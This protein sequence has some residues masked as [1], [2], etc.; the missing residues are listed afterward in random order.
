MLNTKVLNNPASTLERKQVGDF[1]V[2]YTQQESVS[3]MIKKDLITEP[4]D[5]SFL[6]GMFTT[7][8]S[9]DDMLAGEIKY[10]GQV[11]FEG[12]GGVF[13]VTKFGDVWAS[14]KEGTANTIANSLNKQLKENGGKAFLT[15][16][17]GTDS[18]LVSSASG[19]NSTL[20]NLN[21]MLDNNL[22]SPSSF[23]AA[24]STAVRKA[25]GE[26]NLRQSAKDLK[27]DIEKYFK[28][29]KQR[30]GLSNKCFASGNRM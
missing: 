20:A 1:E 3:E 13:F 9:P 14:G 5:V 4:N 8:T 17:K 16:T 23:R 27:I 7:I 24:V 22:I 25:K 15:L 12:E 26:I 28:L 11:I 2:I 30:Y 10:D 19:V 29:V 18:K 6:S 21:N